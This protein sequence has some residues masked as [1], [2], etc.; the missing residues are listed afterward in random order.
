[1][2]LY[3]FYKENN[4]VVYGTSVEGKSQFFYSGFESAEQAKKATYDA[5]LE[6]ELSKLPPVKE[7][8]IQRPLGATKTIIEVSLRGE[9]SEI[10]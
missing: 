9:W 7:G 6:Y 1:M 5:L 10:E 4:K 2:K 3:T 8:C